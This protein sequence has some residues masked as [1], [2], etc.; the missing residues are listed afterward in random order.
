MAPILSRIAQSFGSGSSLDRKRRR[1]GRPALF[2]DPDSR[3][4][5]SLLTPSSGTFDQPAS[6][7]FNGYIAGG[8]G[9]LRTSGN[10][11]LVTMDLSSNPVDGV[12]KVEVLAE[13]GYDS[14]C[15]VTVSGTTYTSSSGS[16]H[17]FFVSGSLTEMTLRTNSVAGRTYMRG[18][19]I[20]DLLLVDE[21]AYVGFAM[22]SSLDQDTKNVYTPTLS[23]GN[24]T[25]SAT[26]TQWHHGRATLG[27]TTGKWY[28]EITSNGGAMVGVEP[29]SEDIDREFFNGGTT[30]GLATRDGKVWFGGT[31]VLTGQTDWANGNVI[32]FAFDADAGRMY[33]Y[34]NGSLAYDYD[35]TMSSA[36]FKKPSYSVYDDWTLTFNFGASGFAYTPPTGYVA[37]STDNGATTS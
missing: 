4:W 9:Q 23:N 5:S 24:L 26:T 11:I 12:A 29:T 35:S 17:T 18:M 31:L 3:V 13:D 20:N 6:L 1:G 16:I 7:A 15:T 27:F 21:D 19:K 14:T 10:Y 28:W 2:D 22:L 32:G 36:A 33:I 34:I 8:D 25:A 37:V 30:A